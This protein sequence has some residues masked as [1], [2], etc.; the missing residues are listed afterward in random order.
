MTAGRW[1]MRFGAIALA[2]IAVVALCAPW[3]APNDPHAQFPDRAFAPPSRVRV[4]HDGRLHAPFIYAQALEDRLLRVYRDDRERPLALRWG[5]G[6]RLVSSGDAAAPLLLLGGDAIGRD[7]FSRLLHGARLSLGVAIAGLAGALVIGALAGAIAGSVGGTI[8]HIL[9]LAADFVIVLPGAYV[10]LVLRGTLPAVLSVG[11]VFALMA[12][13]FA[14]AAWPHVARGVRAI[15]AAE[16][17][18]EYAEAARAAGAGPIRL[19]AHLLPAARGFLAVEI[20]LLLPALLVAEATVSYLGLGFPA[21]VASWGTL[22]QDASAVRVLAEAP[23]LLTPAVA[24][25]LTVLAIQLVVSVRAP[26][27]VLRMGSPHEFERQRA[28]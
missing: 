27:T 7:V 6:G 28:R 26:A 3:L 4:W 1:P 2:A 14:F 21:P 16:R 8:E 5:R 20:A 23:W 18:R 15:V 11:A 25:F 10:V 24:L 22:L 19:A 13:L 9:M 12:G 17:A